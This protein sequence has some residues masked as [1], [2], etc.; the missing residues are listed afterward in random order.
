MK[1]TEDDV[2]DLDADQDD[3]SDGTQAFIELTEKLTLS[4]IIA[5]AA[6][7]CE[8]ESDATAD[9]AIGRE[10]ARLVPEVKRLAKRVK[11]IEERGAA[12]ARWDAAKTT[13]RMSGDFIGQES[14]YLGGEWPASAGARFRIVGVIRRCEG[15]EVISI[16]DNALLARLGGVNARDL[17]DVREIKDNGRESFVTAETYA[18]DF[19]IFAALRGAGKTD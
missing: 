10:W 5:L 3:E 2:Q 4:R 14:R 7:A 15:N 19:E 6:D 16:Q 18:M 1:T 12:R 8:V 17:V 9:D 13:L 11:D